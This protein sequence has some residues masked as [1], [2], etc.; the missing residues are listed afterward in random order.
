MTAQPPSRDY[1]AYQ[2]EKTEEFLAEEVEL[3][4]EDIEAIKSTFS[5]GTDWDD[6]H[7]QATLQR[8]M[9]ERLARKRKKH[10]YEA[11]WRAAKETSALRDQDMGT[12]RA[13]VRREKGSYQER[14]AATFTEQDKE[15]AAKQELIRRILETK[16]EG[17]RKQLIAEN[18]D[19]F[20]EA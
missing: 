1:K 10:D 11:Y 20:I 5:R 13:Q 17:R 4:D 7:V 18:Q 12:Y 6:P 2:T 8:H 3:T 15:E 19:L 14:L 9:D 16:D